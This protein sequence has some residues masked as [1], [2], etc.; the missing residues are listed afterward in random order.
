[1]A[2]T[3]SI[4]Q[5]KNTSA[6]LLVGGMGTRL[7]SVVSSAPKPMA[8]LGGKSFLELLVKQLSQQ[9]VSKLVMC[10]GYLADQ[11]QEHFGDG[12]SWGVSIEY[13]KELQPLGTG[14]AVKLAES[15]LHDAD[16]FL[17]MNGD[18]FME[19]DFDRLFQT[20]LEKKAI[21]TMAVRRVEN[22]SR[23]GAVEL[24]AE[25]RITRF[26]EKSATEMPGIVNAGVYV[27]SRKVLKHIPAGPCSLERDI[28]PKLLSKGM[29][30]V[31]QRGIFIDIGTPEDY[32]KAQQISEKLY[33]AASLTQ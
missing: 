9:G 27:F 23:Y 33:Q 28:F 20:H 7:R 19:V 14:G 6:L 4:H 12:S 16:P 8:T 21:I 17:V 5:V 24:A 32:A 15:Q 1:M 13:S 3:E 31:E 2:F 11:I 26:A 10:T 30:A 29:Y 22:A 25:G 18:S